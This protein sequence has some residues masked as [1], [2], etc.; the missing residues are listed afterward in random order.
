[1]AKVFSPLLGGICGPR[2]SEERPSGRART[3]QGM[4]KRFLLIIALGS[5]LA[6]TGA[7]TASS[8]SV[9]GVDVTVPTLPSPAPPRATRS[10]ASPSP[11]AAAERRGGGPTRSCPS[12][13]RG[14]SGGGSTTSGG[15]TQ[16]RRHHHRLE[17]RREHWKGT[18]TKKARQKGAFA[19]L[20]KQHRGTKEVAMDE[21]HKITQ[22]VLRNPN[23]TPTPPE[24]GADDRA[25]RP[26]P[27]RGPEPRHRLVRDPA[28]PPPDL[29]VLRHRV[30]DPLA[31]AR[32]DQQDRDRLR[33]QPEHLLRRARWAG[34]SSSPRPGRPMASMPTTTAA[35][36]P[37]TRSTRSAPRPAICAPPAATATSGRRSSPTT[38]PTGTSTRCCSGRTS[39]ASS[40]TPWSARSPGSPRAPT[41]RSPPTPATPTTSTTRPRS[42][43]RPP[44]ARPPAMPP[45]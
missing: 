36:T 4:A 6:V 30:R 23:G 20:I 44:S 37:T 38:T 19:K 10:P 33:H 21:R 28:L 1:M 7:A 27:D 24:P 8:L 43:A 39:T 16:L 32:L 14:S 42:P 29:P 18:S 25:V 5:T 11:T 17:R 40:P 41:S 26:R 13:A 31:G 15:S 35:R 3:G 22:P 9:G 34:C 2:R 45:T 12:S